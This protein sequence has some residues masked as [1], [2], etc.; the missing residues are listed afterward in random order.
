VAALNLLSRSDQ[1]VFVA[2]IVFTRARWERAAMQKPLRFLFVVLCLV[3]GIEVVAGERTISDSE[4]K[5]HV[6]ERVA[7]KG[8]VANVFVSEKGTVF[9]N[10]GKPHPKQTFVGVIFGA[11]AGAFPHAEQWEGRT[12]IVRGTVKLY[13]GQPEIIIR[14]RSQLAPAN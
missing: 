10:F 8:V 12:V 5:D 7:V 4:V 14:T 11:D 3:A 2:A 6:G 1:P 9:I 13:G